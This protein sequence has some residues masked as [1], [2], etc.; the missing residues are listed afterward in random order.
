MKKKILSI[1]LAALIIVLMLPTAAFADETLQG[2][3]DNSGT[4]DVY[5][6]TSE[7]QNGFYE[8]YIGEPLG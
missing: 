1:F 7:G 6:T 5:M 2:D 8:T 3:T 4:V